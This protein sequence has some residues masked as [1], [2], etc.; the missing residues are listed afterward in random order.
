MNVF[1]EIAG[2]LGS[3]TI[4]LA[5]GLLS[6]HKISANSRIYQL[7]NITGSLFLM[8]KTLYQRAIP[9]ATLNV[10]WLGIGLFSLFRSTSHKREG[11]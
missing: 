10:F 6:A 5:Y 3:F 1:I 8:L 11:G 2:W 4:L 9:P 7:L